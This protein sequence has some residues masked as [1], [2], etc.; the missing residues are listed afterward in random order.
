[1]KGSLRSHPIRVGTLA[2][3]AATLG[4]ACSAILGVDDLPGMQRPADDG[5]QDAHA[6]GEPDANLAPG[7]LDP[8]FGEGGVVIVKTDASLPPSVV[9]DGLDTVVAIPSGRELVQVMRYS[10]EGALAQYHPV[11]IQWG[12][13]EATQAVPISPADGNGVLVFAVGTAG[14]GNSYTWLTRISAAGGLEQLAGSFVGIPGTGTLELVAR[15]TGFVGIDTLG[16]EDGGRLSMQSMLNDGGPDVP[17]GADGLAQFDTPFESVRLRGSAAQGDGRIVIVGDGL[18]EAA[19]WAFW[20]RFGADGGVDRAFGPDGGIGV[21]K[22]AQT[23]TAVLAD[24]TGYFVSGS[25]QSD[26]GPSDRG[27]ILR[28]GPDGRRNPSYWEG[29]MYEFREPSYEMASVESV[30]ALTSPSQDVLLALGIVRPAGGVPTIAIFRLN[31]NGPDPAFGQNGIA[32][33]DRGSVSGSHSI[34]LRSDGKLLVSWLTPDGT[35]KVA[36]Y[37]V[38]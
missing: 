31:R 20:M 38:R 7:S 14:D 24:D 15:P 32:R 13:A 1:M 29:G 5:G 19:P 12:A 2:L 18:V 34:A 37:I 27:R 35:A 10:H 16:A 11:E 9:A 4:V 30:V 17:F 8:T 28:L 26:G 36:R 3:L 6:M 22:S 33:V 25:A 21:D 23:A